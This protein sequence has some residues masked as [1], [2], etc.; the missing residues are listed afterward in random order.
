MAQK[1]YADL[2]TSALRLIN[3]KA[4]GEH[5]SGADA[6]DALDV[7]NELIDS[8]NSYEGLLFATT[9]TSTPLTGASTY[10]IGPTGSIQATPRPTKLISAWVNNSESIDIPVQILANI[11]YGSIPQKGLTAN[12]PRALYL[13]AGMPNSKIYVYPIGA[14]NG[15]LFLQFNASLSEVTLSTPEVLPPAYRQALR[16]NLAVA[17]GPEYGLEVPPS[18]MMTAISSKSMI[19]AANSTVPRMNFSDQ[20]GLFN[21][22]TGS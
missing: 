13:E 5:A 16:Y 3:V 18:V 10:S 21:I 11:D 7:L 9:T 1:T 4:Q 12:I 19:I 20:F 14:T 15:S 17:L 6:T 22:N 2:I 8:W